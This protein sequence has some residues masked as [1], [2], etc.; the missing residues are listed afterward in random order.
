MP[1]SLPSR[2]N[3]DHLRRQSKDLLTRL[4]E[5]DP[6]AV[7]RFIAHLP[8]AAKQSPA[9]VL[10]AN[11]R[12]ADAQ[13]VIARETGFASWP[14]LARHVELLRALEG[15]WEFLS[16]EIEGSAMPAATYAGSRLLIDGDRFRMESADAVYDGEFGIDVEAEPAQISIEFVEG[17]E[18]GNW[19]YGI[20]E[21]R[22]DALVFCLGLTGA[23]RPSAFATSSGSRHALEHLRRASRARPARVT[24]GK[25]SATGAKPP[26]AAEVDTTSFDGPLT[27]TLVRLQGRWSPTELV[28]EGKPMPREW[29]AAGHRTVTERDTQVVFGGQVMLHARMRVHEGTHPLEVDYLHLSGAGRGEVSLGLIEWVGDTV[30]FLVARPGAPRPASFADDP[31]RE[32]T[33]SSWTRATKG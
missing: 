13:S 28:R 10:A 15:E 18:A 11:Y 6:E 27:P 8:A 26:A 17:P 2:P 14:A 3:L 29:L 33:L 22:G 20:F 5:R 12:L 19:S 25:R 9:Q 1:S 4:R 21:L 7:R 31:G 23:S 16:L 24:G 32:L 30:R